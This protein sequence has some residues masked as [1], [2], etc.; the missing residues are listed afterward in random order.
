MVRGVVAARL[1]VVPC[2]RTVCCAE[3]D[4][5]DIK[6]HGTIKIVHSIDVYVLAL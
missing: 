2:V 6:M 1:G 4:S 5:I 3:W